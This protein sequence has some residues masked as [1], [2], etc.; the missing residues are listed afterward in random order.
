MH[1]MRLRRWGDPDIVHM[2]P[3]WSEREISILMAAKLTDHD[4]RFAGP[5]P[6]ESLAAVAAKLGRSV[7]ACISK[8]R[9]EEAKRGHITGEQ[10]TLE[11]LWTDHE[12]EIIRLNMGVEGKKAP[13]GTWVDVS[14]ILGR[15]HAATQ[16]RAFELRKRD[17]QSKLEEGKGVSF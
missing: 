14:L 9:K 10:W 4:V 16:Q 8:R 17:Q 5:D 1:Y 6:V 3:D 12:D 2:P 11:G 13:L 7:P 15:T